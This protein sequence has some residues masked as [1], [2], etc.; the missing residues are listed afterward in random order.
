MTATLQR[1]ALLSSEMHTSA[2]RAVNVSPAFNGANH[3]SK[4]AAAAASKWLLLPQ[5]AHLEQ[6]ILL[7]V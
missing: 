3:P 1:C 2:D 7:V 4:K 6:H 5:L